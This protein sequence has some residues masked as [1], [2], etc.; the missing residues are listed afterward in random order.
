MTG[1]AVG[2]EDSASR[3]LIR[4]QGGPVGFKQLL[5]SFVLDFRRVLLIPGQRMARM[6]PRGNG[7]AGSRGQGPGRH[8][9]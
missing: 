7:G 8:V 2:T 1:A 6:T 9:S 5:D 3:C 4:E